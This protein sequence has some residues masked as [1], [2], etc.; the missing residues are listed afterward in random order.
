MTSLLIEVERHHQ[1]NIERPCRYK[2][3]KNVFKEATNAL[4]TTLE[5]LE[6]VVL[7]RELRRVTIGILQSINKELH[8]FFGPLSKRFW[9][10]KG[11]NRFNN[12]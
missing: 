12:C 7:D 6:D 4:D 9:Y 2:A 10:A 8:F 3:Q 5:P 11:A 1:S